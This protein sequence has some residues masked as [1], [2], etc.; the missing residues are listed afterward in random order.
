MRLAEPGSV[1]L[2][3]ERLQRI[4]SA[5]NAEIANGTL[6]GAVVAIARQGK[7][8]YHEAFWVDPKEALAVVFMA[9]APGAIRYYHR[10]VM[11]ALV[12]QALE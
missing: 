12:S 2:S 6:P 10:Q 8:A 3:P 11:H 4:G 7:L 5:L 9:H 1:G